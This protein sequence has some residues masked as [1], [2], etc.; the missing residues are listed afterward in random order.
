ME[1]GECSSS[2]TLGATLLERVALIR[3]GIRENSGV[4]LSEVSRLQLRRDRYTYVQCALVV[5]KPG[6]SNGFRP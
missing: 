4:Y 5:E 2:R 6:F 1:H 3:S